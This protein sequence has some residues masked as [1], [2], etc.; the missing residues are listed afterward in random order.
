V[1]DQACAKA[2]IEHRLTP[3]GHPQTNGMVE[4]FNGRI[5]ELVEQTRFHSAAALGATINDYLQVYNHYIPQ[6]AL[7]HLSPIDA[8]KN[9]Q[10]KMPDIFIKKTYN[11]AGLDTYHLPNST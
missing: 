11:Q 8:L 9:W 4:R 10:Q 2:G 3:P 6:R 1:F 5:S 7:G